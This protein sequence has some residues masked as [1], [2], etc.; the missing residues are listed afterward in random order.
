VAGPH[1]TFDSSSLD[2]PHPPPTPPRKGEG[3]LATAFELKPL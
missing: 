3:S 2:Y 1:R